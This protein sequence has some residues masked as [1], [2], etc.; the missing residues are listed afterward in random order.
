VHVEVDA[1]PH[2]NFRPTNLR[3]I[4]ARPRTPKRPP[5]SSNFL[6]LS[7]T[8]LLPLASAQETFTDSAC[9]AQTSAMNSCAK[10]WDSVLLPLTFPSTPCT[11][12]PTYSPRSAPNA[13]S[14]SPQTR[15]GPAPAS[16]RTSQTT[17]P[18]S[19]SRPCAPR[20]SGRRSRSGFGMA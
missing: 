4:M 14:A 15:N 12:S 18:A 17:C 9:R 3:R 1:P 5:S 2:L 6:L 16:A 7:I 10:R 11:H 8:L 20:R 13:P 19:T